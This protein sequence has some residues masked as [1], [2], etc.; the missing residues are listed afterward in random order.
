MLYLI[1]TLVL[2]ILFGALFRKKGVRFGDE[3]II[4]LPLILLIFFMGTSIGASPGVRDSALLIGY[5]SGIFAVLTV[6]GSILGA[7]ILRRFA[8]D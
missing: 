7:V 8:L 6:L 2:G 5:Q 4:T 3:H 1:L